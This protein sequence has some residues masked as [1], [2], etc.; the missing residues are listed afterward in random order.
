L[1]IFAG[2]LDMVSAGV[3]LIIAMTNQPVAACYLRVSTERQTVENQRREVEAL[4]RARG[5]EPCFYEEV[6]SGA[7]ARP[8]LERVVADAR[9]GRVRAVAFWALDRAGRTMQG[10][11]ALVLELDRLGV[12]VLSVREPWLDTGGPVRSLLVA[13]FGWVAEQERARLIERINAGIARAREKGTRSGRAIGRP[14]TRPPRS[15]V[16][17]LR[18]KGLSWPSV[19]VQL[20]SSVGAVRRAAAERAV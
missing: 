14:R 6:E 16:D 9:T 8:V 4:V 17:R 18:A 1:A 13:I 7:K 3:R 2:R 11:V 19:A 20:K 12:Q 15:E 5:Y 10:A